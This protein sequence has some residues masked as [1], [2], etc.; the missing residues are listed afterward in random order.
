MIPYK[1]MAIAAIS[2]VLLLEGC[3]EDADVVQSQVDVRFVVL[4]AQGQQTSVFKAGENVVF[5][6]QI[7]NQSDQ[8]LLLD[9]PI[10]LDQRFCEVRKRGSSD[11][12]ISLGKPYNSIFCTY[13]GGHVLPAHGSQT[14]QIPWVADS[15][16]LTTTH[17]CSVLHKQFLPIGRY[18][19]SFTTPIALYQNNEQIGEIP[20]RTYTVEFEV[21]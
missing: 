11:E 9:N 3:K 20:E 21:R 19:S 18:Y 7:M 8:M 2:S 1:Y 13:Q 4:N 16:V 12:Q 5:R 14:I 17:F 10:F 6:L 15:T